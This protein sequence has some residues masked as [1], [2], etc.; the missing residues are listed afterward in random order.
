MHIGVMQTDYRMTDADRAELAEIE[1]AA[2]DVKLRR[3]RF[4]SK[5]RQRAYR[6]RNAT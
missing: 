5:L 1:K 6:A 4:W 2:S 3:K